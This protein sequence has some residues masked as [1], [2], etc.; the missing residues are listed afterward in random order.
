MK[1]KPK[2]RGS[3]RWEGMQTQERWRRETQR[4]YG[5]RNYKKRGNERGKEIVEGGKDK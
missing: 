5:G 2:K 3:E 4:K 1:G